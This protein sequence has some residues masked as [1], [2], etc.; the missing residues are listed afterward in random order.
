[1]K[2]FDLV[3]QNGIV[4][5]ARTQYPANIYVKDGKIAAITGREIELTAEK[6][7]D[8]HGQP[9][10]PGCVDGHTHL[11]DP[12]YT[13]RETFTTG[14]MA[15]A[16]G[17]YTTV[18]DH[19]RTIPAV[20]SLEPLLEKIEYL[21]DKAVVDFALMG[22]LSPENKKDL[23]AMWDAGVSSFK[24]FTCNLHG[25]RAMHSGYLLDTFREIASFGGRALIHSEDDG[26]IAFEEERM[27]REGR[28]DPMAHFESRSKL[29]EEVGV[30]TVLSI[31]R[32]TGAN[33]GIAHVSQPHL[34]VEIRQLQE[35]GYPVFSETQ[36]H[37]L[38]M[39]TEDLKRLG[40]W[41]RF[42]PPVNTPQMQEQL[43]DLFNKGI[44]DTIG[45]DHCP[46]T[47]S[48]KEKGLNA[49]LDAPCGIPG[50]ETALKLMLTGVN[51][52]KTS[53]N[54]VV[55][56]MSENPAKIYGLYPRKGVI[57]AGADADLVILN[58]EKEEILSN[59]RV[60]SKCGW[61]PYHGMKIKGCPETVMVRGTIVFQ[62][63]KVVGK[64]G[65]GK[66]VP[67]GTS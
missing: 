7:I 59:E 3:I 27:R 32:A 47:K 37:Y 63:G 15:A 22:G 58:M 2:Q 23:R 19:H 16:A 26:L 6:Q 43:W 10:I 49:V 48:D 28:T 5:S 39:N 52:G 33:I 14:T 41:L 38:C 25:V 11:M 64:A 9:V 31:A 34:A 57:E 44:F 20:Y 17:G 46:I 55:E 53:L 67:R 30:R 36:P 56:C 12:G 1:M 62:D 40:P 60:I 50:L 42:T 66:F 18:T 21:K 4:V 45:T 54:R 35:E 61:T 8:A 24:G 51:Q 29:S 13:E 65:Y